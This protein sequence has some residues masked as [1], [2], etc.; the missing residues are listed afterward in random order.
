MEHNT[1]DNTADLTPEEKR[2]QLYDRQVDL[3]KKFLECGAISKAQYDKSYRDLTAKM[4]FADS[5]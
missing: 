3:L 2:R 5:E 1:S 4:G